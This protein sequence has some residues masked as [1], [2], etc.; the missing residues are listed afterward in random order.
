MLGCGHA[1]AGW[2]HHSVSALLWIHGGCYVIGSAQQDDKLSHSL[3]RRCRRLAKGQDWSPRWSTAWRPRTHIPAA[4]DDGA[5]AV[6]CPR[7]V[8]RSPRAVRQAGTSDL[9]SSGGIFVVHVNGRRGNP[10]RCGHDWAI[11]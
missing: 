3:T 10:K 8:G 6:S 9:C 1:P 4:I 2:P 11:R 7:R 5:A